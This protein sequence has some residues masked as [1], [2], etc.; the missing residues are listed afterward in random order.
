MGNTFPNYSTA[1][2]ASDAYRKLHRLWQLAEQYNDPNLPTEWIIAKDRTNWYHALA[3]GPNAISAITFDSPTA[4][5]ICQ[6]L[7]KGEIEL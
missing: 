6:M 5:K 4:E 7:N 2:K 1:E 3:V